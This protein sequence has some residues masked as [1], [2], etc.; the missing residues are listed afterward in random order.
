MSLKN[1]FD[2]RPWMALGLVLLSLGGLAQTLR[3]SG[4]ASGVG[5]NVSPNLLAT[6]DRSVNFIVALV[7][8]EPITNHDVRMAVERLRVQAQQSGMSVPPD[9]LANDALELLIFERSQLQWAV[10]TGVK[11][12]EEELESL[13]ASVAA[14]NQLSIEDFYRALE[15]QGVSQKRFFQNLREQQILQRLRDRDV[16]GRINI[17]EPEIDRF[18]TRQKAA[19]VQNARLELA[20]ILV[21]LP[22]AATPEQVAQADQTARQWRRDIEQGADFF[23]LAR[24]RSQ[25]MDR[26]QGG[27]MGMREA[28]RYPELFVQATQDLPVGGV[29]G[30]VRSGAGFHLLKLIERQQPNVL[31]MVQTR[32]RHI[33][34]KPGGNLSQAAARARLVQFKSEIERGMAD[35]AQ[36]AREQSQDGSASDGGDLGWATPGQFVPEF[37]QVMNE[38]QP[39]QISEP[40]VSRFGVH[41]I[42]VNE[43]R[44]VP[45]TP[46]QERE[47]ARNALRETKYNETL[48]SWAKELRGRAF[49]EYREPPQ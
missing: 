1:V 47:Y 42:Q 15:R 43:R 20:Q 11:V 41:L 29:A 2:P 32:A 49:I 28:N 16:P 3:A 38:L 7:D 35:F 39:G 27:R 31:T 30:P 10:Q 40:L 5:L 19:L 4:N 36:V 25:A 21:S 22:D 48:E 46:R 8:N 17:T 9:T 12:N 34:L 37:E 33:L 18:L 24:Q 44:E 14:R 45:L 6:P 26:Q 13:A 23:D